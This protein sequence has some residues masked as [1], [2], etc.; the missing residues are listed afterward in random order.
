MKADIFRIHEIPGENPLSDALAWRNER[1]VLVARVV[2]V[3][4][5]VVS[6]TSLVA[7]IAYG[8]SCGI[9]GALIIGSFAVILSL[10]VDAVA[11]QLEPLAPGQ[12][13][14]LVQATED[15][16]LSR[17]TLQSWLASVRTIR[18]RDFDQLMLDNSK[19]Q[20]ERLK[21]EMWKERVKSDAILSQS[22]S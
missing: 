6:L 20:D 15:Q 12:L 7:G 19:E 22:V 14:E 10:F 4:M 11:K 17:E 13:S 16:P 8:V 21:S 9:W 3:G 1:S 18:Q 5:L 2:T